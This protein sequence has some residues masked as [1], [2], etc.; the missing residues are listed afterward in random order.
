MLSSDA[1]HTERELGILM[2]ACNPF[3]ELTEM[4]SFWR[5]LA[6]QSSQVVRAWIRKTKT[7]TLLSKHKAKND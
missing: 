2:H 5:S 7:K 3:V 4:G 6:R 1:Q